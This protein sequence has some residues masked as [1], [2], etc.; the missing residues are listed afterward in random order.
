MEY[1]IV[2]WE[3]EI[4]RNLLYMIVCTPKNFRLIIL[5]FK[6]TDKTVGCLFKIR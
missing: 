5:Y 2:L 6:T 3:V 4:Y 1:Y